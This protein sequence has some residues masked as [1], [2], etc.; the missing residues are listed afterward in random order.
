MSLSL[1]A[2][3]RYTPELAKALG[4]DDGDYVKL[5]SIRSELDGYAW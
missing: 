2:I 1:T 3:S 4:I 5:E